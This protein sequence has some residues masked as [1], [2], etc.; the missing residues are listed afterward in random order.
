MLQENQVLAKSD[1][2]SDAVPRAAG[3][4]K[5]ACVTLTMSG[6]ELALTCEDGEEIF[7]RQAASCLLSPAIGDKV[8]VC[9][10]GDEAFVLSVLVRAEEARTPE[11]RVPGAACLRVTAENELEFSSKVM[12]LKAGKLALLT[13]VLAQS[14]GS[15]TLH[16]KRL[17]ETVVEKFSSARTL[18]VKAE[19]RSASISKTDTVAAGAL[20]QKIDGVALQNSEITLI[21]AKQD[22]RVDGERIS[23][24]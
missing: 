15:V 23:L 20:V 12:R 8:L 9:L 5:T 3:G 13:D 14:A 11:V 16:A 6:T 7:A 21:N 1:E 10:A 18:T 24:G 2:L 22:V 19:N 4:L 17:V